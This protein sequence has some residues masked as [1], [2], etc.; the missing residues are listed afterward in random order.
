M[1]L[2]ATLNPT[3]K[4]ANLVDKIDRITGP[5]SYLLIS[6]GSENLENL[7]YALSISELLFLKLPFTISYLSK[8]KDFKALLYWIPK[9]IVSNANPINSL[10]DIFPAYKWRAESFY[11]GK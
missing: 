1:S 3:Q 6:S 8:T 7:G 9:E 5:L 10:L 4:Y 2:E 11:K